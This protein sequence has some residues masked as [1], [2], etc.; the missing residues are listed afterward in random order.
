M[1]VCSQS[2]LLAHKANALLAVKAVSEAV[3]AVATVVVTEVTAA[4][5]TNPL[6]QTTSPPKGAMLFCLVRTKGPDA[7]R[8]LKVHQCSSGTAL[9]CCLWGPVENLGHIFPADIQHCSN[10]HVAE[11]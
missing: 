5:D 3:I 6:R 9:S 11:R 10:D 4:A 8:V 2:H 1:G 7:S